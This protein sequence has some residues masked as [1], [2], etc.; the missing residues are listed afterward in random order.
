MSNVIIGEIYKQLKKKS[1]LVIAIVAIIPFAFSFL[2]YAHPSFLEMDGEFGYMSYIV[3]L[4]QSMWS[5][6]IPRILVVY[7]ITCIT[8]DEIQ[9]Q[10]LYE[11]SRIPNRN[12]LALGRFLSIMILIGEYIIAFFVS[13]TA[14]FWAFIT[15]TEYY[16]SCDVISQEEIVQL[17][18][19]FLLLLLVISFIYSISSKV[20]PIITMVIVIVGHVLLST[21]SYN[22]KWEF[23]PGTLAYNMEYNINNGNMPLVIIYQSIILI[24]LISLCLI[25]KKVNYKRMEVTF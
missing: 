21:I 22:E 6:F 15:K 5:M 17:W 13:A 4:W 8:E 18:I 7:L 23:V 20:K 16:N 2:I 12:I 19:G 25:I 1:V 10:I 11:L 3:V 24:I 9:G 14:G